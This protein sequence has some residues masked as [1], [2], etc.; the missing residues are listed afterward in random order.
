MTT[1]MD[2]SFPGQRTAT[3][4]LCIPHDVYTCQEPRAGK[5]ENDFFRCDTWLQIFQSDSK[6]CEAEVTLTPLINKIYKPW[7]FS[8]FEKRSMPQGLH[9][10]YACTCI[11]KINIP[12]TAMIKRYIYLACVMYSECICCG[13][14]LSL[15]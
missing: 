4:T 15:V 1:I 3:I 6:I 14:I 10:L 5:C 2:L 11:E 13:S 12:F 7:L 9:V 8:I